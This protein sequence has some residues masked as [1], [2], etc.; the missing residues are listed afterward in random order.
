MWLK[1]VVKWWWF[2]GDFGGFPDGLK[3]FHG[4]FKG[5]HSDFMGVYVHYPLSDIKM[6]YRL[7]RC[8]QKD[9]EQHHRQQSRKV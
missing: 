8:L 9:V 5:F 7:G 4:D 2:Q 6:E 1:S 3:G